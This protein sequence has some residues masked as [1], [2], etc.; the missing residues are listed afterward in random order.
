MTFPGLNEFLYP[1]L[2]SVRSQKPRERKEVI[3]DLIM[4]L[5]LTDEQLQQRTKSNVPLI[6]HRFALCE[7]LLVRTG[8]LI[9]KRHSDDPDKDTFLITQLGLK[10]LYRKKDD[11]TVG[12]LQALIAGRIYRGS[13]SVD[14]RSEAE[15][16]L[17]E[18]LEQ[19]PAI[20][21][22]FHSVGWVAH[23][24][25][26]GSVGEIDFVIA[27]PTY[28]LLV[29]E[30][31]GG[32]IAVER[33]GSYQA[34]TSED[35][36]GRV[37]E[38]NDP[39]QQAE[40]N[41]RNLRA[42]LANDRRTARFSYA[43][44]PAVSFPDTVIEHDI[45]P[46]FPKQVVIDA[47][48]I[49]NLSQSIERVFAYWAQRADKQNSTMSGQSA[50]DALI[51]LFVP[52]RKL[53]NSLS[54]A[55]ERERK[56]IDELTQRQFHILSTLQQHR[57]AAIVGGAGTGKTMLAMEKAHQLAIAGFRV[58]FLAYNRN[59]VEW[60]ARNLID[61]EIT[62]A[63]FHSFVGQMLHL[64]K[65]KHDSAN[66]DAF[67]EQAAELLMSAAQ[68]VRKDNHSL[69]YDAVIVDEAQDFEDTWWIALT[70][71]LKSTSNGIFYVFFDDNQRIYQQMTNIPVDIPPFHLVDNCRNTQKIH[72]FARKYAVHDGETY[73]DG[74]L[75]RSVSTM[76]ANSPQEQR[77]ALG[78][79]LHELSERDV[80][81]EEIVVLTPV[82]Q[83][84]SN[85]KAGDS[86]GNFVLTWDLNSNLDNAIRVSTIYS[87]KGLETAI[88][89][90]TELD[91]MLPHLVNQLMYVALSRARHDAYIIGD[92]P[93]PQ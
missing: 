46:D 61:E 43:V 71:V 18:K 53:G 65:I 12:Y 74:P 47:R 23:D 56:K 35:Y 27:H 82:S 36:L 34:W 58:L 21:K 31:K 41:R 60:I 76:S 49:Q 55:F 5:K 11:L 68:Q 87:Y 1:I 73:C 14:T 20:Y 70:E 64:A 10:Q 39:M 13:G 59:I 91:G 62:V 17:L 6:K 44:F 37:N 77:R 50:V 38:I 45:R 51:E 16:E 89:I 72:A 9:K 33:K 75:G 66:S 92:H 42:W 78:Q 25:L 85:W 26:Y 48:D 40:R 67:S 90:L 54:E 81:P 8:F 3:A 29:L 19:L 7:G 57:R 52:S 30:V 15:L 63:T 2:N 22:V 4:R 88:V 24:T 69:L 80:L 93:K 28:G 32:R 79:I 86:I 83:Q 84:R